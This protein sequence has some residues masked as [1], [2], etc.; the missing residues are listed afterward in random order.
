MAKLQREFDNQWKG[1]E[2]WVKNPVLAWNEIIQSMRYKSITDRD[3]SKEEVIAFLDKKVDTKI[4]T[5]EGEKNITISPL[6][7]ILH[8]F[9]M[10]Q[11]GL[12]TIEARTGYVKAWVG[13]IDYR[14]FKYDHVTSHRQA[15]STFKPVIYAAALEKG[16]QPCDY[17]RNDSTVYAAYNNWVPKNSAQG[18]GGSYS[19]SGALTHSVNTVSAALLMDVGFQTVTELASK[20][21]FEGDLPHVPSLALGSGTVSVFELVQAY[22]AFV[23]HG[24]LVSPVIIQRIE[25]Q[26]GN[27]IYTGGPA[28]GKES[29]ISRSTAETMAAMLCNVV[30]KG[31]AASLRSIYGFTSEMAGKTGTTQDHSDGWYVGFTPD[32]I[33]A[34]WVGGNNPIVH[35]PTLTYGQGAYMAL[36]IYAGLMQQVYTDQ[37]YRGLKNSS[38]IFSDTTLNKL[39][40]NDFKQEEFESIKDFLEK[41]EQSIVDFVKKVFRKKKQK[42]DS[43]SD[44]EDT[45]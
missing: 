31:T 29:I 2:P 5:W 10:L 15:G 18:Y 44:V 26:H 8:H 27:V 3:L 1:K 42:P 30:N 32:L 4:F 6:D 35:F 12:L 45:E 19:V 14:Y 24:Y 20:M 39:V 41:S 22:S 40:C 23:N 7:S 28:V 21:G 36:P 38:F 13:G 25:D 33:T 11:A 9:S 37:V 17:Y 16:I 34:V 43:N